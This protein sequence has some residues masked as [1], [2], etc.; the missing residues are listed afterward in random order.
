MAQSIKVFAPATIANLGSGF[1]LLGLAVYGAGDEIIV[2]ENNLNKLFIEKIT[3]DENKLP[4]E[5]IENTCTVAMQAMLDELKIK[6]GFNVAINKQMPL[7]SGMGSSA[8]SAVGG[9]FA[10]N[11]LLNK[12]FTKTELIQFALEGE[13][14][15]SRGYHADNIAPCMLGGITFISS[16]QPLKMHA[17]PCPD[18]FYI[19]LLHQPVQI[20]TAEARKIL[21]PHYTRDIV[22]KQNAAIASFVNGLH[23]NDFESISFGLQDFIAEPYRKN[24]IPH[25]SE[26]KNI[27][28]QTGAVGYNISGS[29][30]AVFAVSSEKET[31]EKIAHVWKNYFIEINS[32]CLCITSPINKEGVKIIS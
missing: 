20:L 3:G 19:T 13:Y 18:N 4:L 2:T 15:A 26:L 30:P 31:A 16:T 8:A 7:G 6:T 32:P 14:I 12:P 5:T 29:G 27:A 23:Q 25:Y 28:M 22:I 24:L 9:V 10:L 1:D 17:L 21:P 11:E